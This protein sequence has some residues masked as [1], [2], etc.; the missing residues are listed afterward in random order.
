[1]DLKYSDVIY[2]IK[3]YLTEKECEQLIE[4]YESNKY[5]FYQEDSTNYITNSNDTAKSSIVSLTPGT[6]NYNLVHD[7]SEK[8]ITKWIE[9]L[10]SY[11]SFFTEILKLNLN[12]ANNYRILKYETGGYIHPHIDWT[13]FT[14][15]SLTFNLNDDYE[16]GEFSFFNGK[17][18]FKLGVGDA[19]IFPA[20]FF[21][22]HEVK[23]ILSGTRY[24][25]NVNI[26]S[27]PRK[28]S[29]DITSQ[30]KSMMRSPEIIDHTYYKSIGKSSKFQQKQ[31]IELQKKK[32]EQQIEQ[33][34][35]K[36]MEIVA[37]TL[38]GCSHC[39]T[40]KEL[41]KRAKTDYTEVVVKRDMSLDEFSST[42]PHIT[43]FPF[44]VVNGNQIGGLV[45]TVK[46]FVAQGLVTSSKNKNDGS[47]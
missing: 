33:M 22:V 46:L 17:N 14:H 43:V 20:D 31:K 19:I 18:S 5:S 21:W 28:Y 47:N 29:Q 45:E 40:L 6:N 30:V 36:S 37:Y 1:M 24:S 41:F 11:E 10:D 3:N 12:Y 39:K 34:S 42:Y 44:V 15:A 38:S 16:G 23:P 27:L 4:E 26:N 13:H 8:F 32:F 2:I 35:N 25:M 7:R 9:H